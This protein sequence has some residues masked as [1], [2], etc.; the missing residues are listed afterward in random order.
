MVKSNNLEELI[1]MIK[2]DIGRISNLTRKGEPTPAE[3]DEVFELAEDI[4]A[5][6]KKIQEIV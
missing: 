2:S 1:D 4:E 5:E 3:L 6:A